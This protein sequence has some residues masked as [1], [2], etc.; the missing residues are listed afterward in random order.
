MPEACSSPALQ[1]S[2]VEALIGHVGSRVEIVCMSRAA[3][4]VVHVA[5]P[6]R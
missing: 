6:Q 2:N 5:Q 3:R 1:G 4:R